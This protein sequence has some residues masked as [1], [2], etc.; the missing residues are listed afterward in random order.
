MLCHVNSLKTRSLKLLLDFTY[1]DIIY[2]CFKFEVF[3]SN[4]EDFE[5][6][7]VLYIIRV[8]IFLI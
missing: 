1:L 3:W 4:A 5:K 7:N 8:C 2:L 6:K